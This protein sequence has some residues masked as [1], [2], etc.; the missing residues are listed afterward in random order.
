MLSA[1]IC[2]VDSC[3]YVC[4]GVGTVVL[5]YCERFICGV[6]LLIAVAVC[7]RVLGPLFDTVNGCWDRCIYD[8]VNVIISTIPV[9]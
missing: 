2:D 9:Q 3:G 1:C 4:T 7:V 8:T 6:E 5:R